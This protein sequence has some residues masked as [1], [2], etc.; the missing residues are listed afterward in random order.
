MSE[1]TLPIDAIL[2]E[3]GADL[4][5]AVHDLQERVN[6]LSDVEFEQKRKELAAEFGVRTSALDKL[7]RRPDAQKQGQAL[8]LANPV[9]A[10]EPQAGKKLLDDLAA[11]IRRFIAADAGSIDAITLWIVFAHI[12]DRAAVCPNLAFVSATKACGKSTALDVV[13]RLI[14]RSIN[15]AN[16]TPAAL[17]RVIEAAHPSLIIDEADTMFRQNEELR[18]LLNAGFTRSAAQ[19]L[20]TVGDDYEPRIFT[21]WAA[22]AFAL[23][24]RLPD[25]LES[26]SVVIRMRR[27]LPDEVI[28]RLR[29]DKDQGFV[30]L[31]SR[32]ARFIL[33]NAEAIIG[34]EPELPEGLSDRQADVWRELC[35]I[36]DIA[37]GD[38]PKRAQQAALELCAKSDDDGDLSIRLLTDIQTIFAESPERDFWPSQAIVDALNGLDEAPWADL[39]NG[40]GLTTNRLARMLQRFEIKTKTVRMGNR[41]PKGYAASSFADIFARYL[42][43][44]RNTQQ[45]RDNS[46]HDNNIKCCGIVSVADGNRNIQETGR[47]DDD[48]ASDA[49][50]TT[51]VSGG[52]DELDIF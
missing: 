42:Q 30:E 52:F 43:N 24:G 47:N 32:I 33:D 14:P 7:R 48:T 9:P 51:G 4:Q 31:Q 21:V 50:S 34:D 18:C 23:I 19:V 17:F 44:N 28:E 3:I 40:K 46:L 45:N 41:T 37:G 26:R 35:R 27:R 39:N 16:I 20:R 5:P 49:G 1:V 36:A 15:I 38:W 12:A 25:T 29:S 22:K 11:Q 8:A 13:S 2:H 10:S 6:S